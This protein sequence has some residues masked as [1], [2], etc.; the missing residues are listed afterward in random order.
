MK[1]NSQFASQPYDSSFLGI[2]PSPLSDLQAPTTQIAVLTER[3]QDVVG[4]VHEESA[5]IAIAGLGDMKLGIV[6]A[7]LVLLWDQAKTRTDFTTFPETI[8]IFEGEDISQG[9]ERT[10]TTDVSEA[11]WFQDNES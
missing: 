11:A 5:K 9:S 6:L 4:T 1:Q 10:N 3:T 2:L 7:G 8:G